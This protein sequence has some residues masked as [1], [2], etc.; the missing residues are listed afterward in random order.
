MR[1]LL[2]AP[3]ISAYG[4]YRLEGPLA[5]DSARSFAAQGAHS[6]IGHDGTADFLAARLG[7]PVPCRRDAIRMQPGDQALVLRLLTRLPE[8]TVLDATALAAVD[9]EFALLTRLS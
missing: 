8:G 3:V 5:L 9:H 2:N 7:V 6:A 4:D 1:Y